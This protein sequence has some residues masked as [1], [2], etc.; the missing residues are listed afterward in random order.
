MLLSSGFDVVAFLIHLIHPLTA[1]PE[2]EQQRIP[3]HD[4]E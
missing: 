2:K 4:S 1:Q 3:G